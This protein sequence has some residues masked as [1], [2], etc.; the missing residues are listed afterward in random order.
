MA[1]NL[2]DMVHKKAAKDDVKRSWQWYQSN[3][4]NASA[5]MSAQKFLGDNI[6]H[7]S[8]KIS[9]GSMIQY[10]YDPKGKK[11]LPYYDKFPL[12]LPFSADATH[13]T[14][15]N[16]HYISPL[17]R[18]VLLDKLMQYVSD[19]TLTPQSK[20]NFTWNMLK[21]ASG[22]PEIKHC[23]KQYLFGHVKSNYIVIPP[24]EWKFVCWLPLERFSG[25]TNEQ[26]WSASRK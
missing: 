11:E 1:N 26:V 18:A 13:F 25:A 24:V 9:V 17:H 8:S 4:R 2:R 23:V 6:A 10:F 21:S 22:L 19:D 20:F 12:V 7:Q 5:N 3:V 14:G 16:L 15:L